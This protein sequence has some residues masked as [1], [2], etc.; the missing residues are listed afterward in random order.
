MIFDRL[1]SIITNTQTLKEAGDQTHESLA[2]QLTN[3]T[4][5]TLSATDRSMFYKKLYSSASISVIE[6]NF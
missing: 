4:V 2:D 5:K 6:T 3:K 1:K